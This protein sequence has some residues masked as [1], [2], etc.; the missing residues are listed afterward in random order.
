M[1]NQTAE[2]RRKFFVGRKEAIEAFER[3]LEDE[4]KR[5][6]LIT[7]EG[8]IGKTW[9]LS[10]L[11]E[12]AEK[13]YPQFEIT[14]DLIDLLSTQNHRISQLWGQIITLS[15]NPEPFSAH[16]E[17]YAELRELREQNQGYPHSERAMQDKSSHVHALFYEGCNAL[18]GTHVYWFDTF[19]AVRDDPVGRW[20]LE[21]LPQNA[22]NLRLVIA[23]RPSNSEQGQENGELI[24]PYQL[25][26]LNPSDVEHFY[27]NRFGYDPRDDAPTGAAPDK[28][29][30]HRLC[31]K[32]NYHP[33]HIDLARLWADAALIDYTELS[34]KSQDEIIRTLFDHL[35]TIMRVPGFITPELNRQFTREELNEIA[36][37][38]FQV[39][40]YMAYLDR[41]FNKRFLQAVYP[42]SEETPLRYAEIALERM[43]QVPA[44]F[45]V[46]EREGG[47][48]REEGYLQLHDEVRD[49]VLDILWEW[50]DPLY[51]ERTD[52]AQ[53]AID[54]YD[55]I[56]A[57]AD[58][59]HDVR[60]REELKV[61]K[62]DYLLRVDLQE[63]YR[64]FQENFERNIENQ[65][66]GICQLLLNEIT[67][68]L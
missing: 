30:W 10:E 13:N 32:L 33:L 54:V 39:V 45:F 67:E 48:N 37:A 41:R 40:L 65:N 9:L 2:L 47:L 3:F 16:Q 63:G 51:E 28:D 6:F 11:M 22:E 14:Q 61:E 53:K 58:E 57:E 26:G 50:R 42:D 8:G 35:Q 18:E 15:G 52:L 55:H 29:V 21:E 24:E 20:L 43:G 68:Y 7:G 1:T 31:E 44:I 25:S 17:E 38:A 4:T 62:L 60:L 64:Q 23:G 66:W 19:E 12:H 27:R 46:K 56:I 36:I 34:H 5:I 49:R 59:D